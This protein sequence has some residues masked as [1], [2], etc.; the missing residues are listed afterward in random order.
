MYVAEQVWEPS[1]Q[2][3]ISGITVHRKPDLLVIDKRRAFLVEISCP[4]DRFVNVCYEQKFF[5]YQELCNAITQLGYRYSVV[6][7]E[8]SSTGLVHRLFRTGLKMLGIAGT[9]A[10]A[11]AR[12]CSV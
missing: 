8:V 11:I 3:G 10:T 1:W 5:K 4:F 2:S 7:L 6:V 9:V 12:Y